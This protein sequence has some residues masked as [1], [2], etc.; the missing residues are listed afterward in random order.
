MKLI[1]LLLSLMYTV[2]S[3][4]I[5]DE[6]KLSQ[7]SN[8][9][10]NYF[11]SGEFEEII[12]FDEIVFENGIIGTKDLNSLKNLS[13][14]INVYKKSEQKFY[15]SIIGHTSV[16][17]DDINENAIDSGTYANKIQNIFR[18]SFDTNE[19]ARASRSYANEVKEY[20]IEHNV[21]E[22]IIHL[23]YRSGLDNAYS[24][25]TKEGRDLSNRV[26]VTLY[27]EKNLDIDAD[28]VVNSRDLCPDTQK[29]YKVDKDGCKFKTIVLLVE[30]KKDYNA[31][32]VTTEQNTRVIK[33]ARDYT[34]IK[35]KNDFPKL[36]KSMSDEEMQKIFADVLES[37]DVQ[38]FNIYFNSRD[39]LN[40]D[41]KLN[42]IIQFLKKS[43]E[44]Y[45]Q[46]IGHTDSKGTRAYNEDLAQKRAEIVAQ[47]IKESGVKYLHIQVE[48]YGENNLAVKTPDGI[49]EAL[50]RRVEVLIR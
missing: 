6:Y 43:K 48:S 35:S 38:T 33:Q 12:R 24:D 50:N 28:G 31:I 16:T 23:E 8:Q 34:L 20:L 40:V 10:Q 39:F 36:Y 21:S 13:E 27:A 19:S 3:A 45:I 29:G 49:R 30:N 17:T 37:N 32:S 7:D 26:M 25:A 2:V 42:E 4:D 9:T 14:K 15:L 44:S 22:K 18:D 5:Y 47:K 46:V 41:T 11:F 1:V